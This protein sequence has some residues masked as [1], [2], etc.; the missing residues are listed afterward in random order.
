MMMSSLIQVLKVNYADEDDEQ[1]DTAMTHPATTIVNP[2]L[3]TTTTAT[4]TSL[5]TA[6]TR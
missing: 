4:S 1:E 2:T 5:H 3:T 6:T